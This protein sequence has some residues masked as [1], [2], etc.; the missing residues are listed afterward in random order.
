MPEFDLF[1]ERTISGK[2][3][4]RVPTELKKRRAVVLYCDLIRPPMSP[5]YNSGYSPPQSFYGNITFLRE[6]YVIGEDKIKYKQQ[7][8]SDVPDITAQNL[9][10]IKCMYKGLLQSFVNQNTALGLPVTGV[11][12]LIQDYE[13]LDL[14]WDEAR[15]CCYASTALKLRLYALP[16]D[17]CQDDA[18]K[19]RKPR[20]PPPPPP[21]VPPDDPVSVDPPYEDDPDNPDN[22]TEPYEGDEFPPDTEG[23][24]CQLY[25]FTFKFNIR[26]GGSQ[27]EVVQLYGDYGEFG[28]GGFGTS[29]DGQFQGYS[30]AYLDC[31]GGP[32]SVEP[33]APTCLPEI[34]RCYFYGGPSPFIISIEL[35]S[36]VPV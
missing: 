22:V 10:A 31:R 12:D 2:G 11:V 30:N 19:P 34:T 35:L 17:K 21:E 33:N 15:I 3:M 7:S 36:V 25:T 8:W 28:L 29:P 5:Y 16:N 24:V 1:Q 4:L 20:K 6:G 13:Y 26:G 9:I 14:M 27:N 23:E 32:G 18:D